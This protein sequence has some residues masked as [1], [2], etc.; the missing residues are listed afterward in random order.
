V[1]IAHGRR[2]P[3][4]GAE[5]EPIIGRTR[6]RGACVVA[7][8][9]VSS[10]ANAGRETPVANPPTD[11]TRASR[12]R[13]ALKRAAEQGAGALLVTRAE[14]VQYLSGFTGEDSFLLLGAGWATLI[15]DGRFGEQ[16]RRECGGLE[17]RVRRG[18]MPGAVAE[19]LKG[20]RV[21]A[22]GV[23]SA[24]VTVALSDQLAWAVAK[25][26]LKPVADVMAPL[27]AV[28]DAGEVRA[29]R[30]AVRVAQRAL[31]ELLAGGA[32]GLVGRRER[33]VAAELDY[34][35]RCAGAQEAS[36][37]TIVA[38]GA[39]SS[40]PHYRPG[41]RRL[42]EGQAVLIDWGA[43]VGG[44]CSDLTRTFFLGRIPPKLAAAYRAVLGAQRAA[45]RACRAGVKAGVPDAAAKR[46]MESAGFG[47][48]ILHGVGHGVGLEVHEGPVLGRGARTRL[49][50]GMVVT[51][52]PGAYLP[53]IGGVRIEDDVLIT[54]R[55]A[56][57]LSS[58][59][60]S[61]QAA[62]LR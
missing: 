29:I 10:W 45:M 44:Y 15:T 23:V 20:R 38:A 47:A 24:A 19:A 57:R 56:R 40:R 35:M 42:R 6:A 2:L 41:A 33:D 11:R 31:R 55:G 34:R 3:A 51:I 5:A 8:A 4:P 1:G 46:V 58:M 50:A 22:L 21:R 12:R 7:A 60:R 9:A 26:R 13:R 37:E 17:V 36:F 61:L 59:A 39:H 52:E 27:R 62:R 16:A 30:R 14:D 28:K 32:A 49:R 25:R 43:R 48:G 54:P 53:G 18:P